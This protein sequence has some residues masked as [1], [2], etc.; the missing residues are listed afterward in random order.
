MEIIIKVLMSLLKS[1]ND[2]VSVIQLLLLLSYV[3][4]NGE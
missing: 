1:N 4:I 2:N 3:I